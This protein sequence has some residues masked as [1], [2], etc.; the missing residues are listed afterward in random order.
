MSPNQLVKD[1]VL[2]SFWSSLDL[3]FVGTRVYFVALVCS[4]T[5]PWWWYC[6][7]WVQVPPSPGLPVACL[8]STKLSWKARGRCP[9][10]VHA[11]HVFH[12]PVKQDPQPSIVF[13]QWECVPMASDQCP[14]IFQFFYGN[15]KLF[16]VCLFVC[17][18]ST[19]VYWKHSCPFQI[20]GK[21]PVW[22][23]LISPCFK[24]GECLPKWWVFLTVWADCTE[25]SHLEFL[26]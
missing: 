23:G 21:K 25:T 5:I 26:F 3:G 8:M 20:N 7:P 10:Y 12:V 4:R 11:G 16:F 18:K 13:L 14:N 24:N 19:A 22:C 1:H 15:Q 17:L 6:F 2:G 9:V